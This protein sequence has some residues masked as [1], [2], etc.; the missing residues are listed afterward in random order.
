MHCIVLA[1]IKPWINLHA[2]PLTFECKVSVDIGLVLEL[3]LHSIS[4]L[5][6][7]SVLT[8]TF[9]EVFLEI[10]IV[11]AFAENVEDFIWNI[12]QVE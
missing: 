8:N 4:T 7:L 10:D 11:D 1:Y 12:T 9:H 2:L 5:K 3:P 6:T